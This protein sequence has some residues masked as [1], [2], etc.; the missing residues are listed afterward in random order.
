[1]V[2]GD[3]SEIRQPEIPG[4]PGITDT[5]PSSDKGAAD[6]KARRRQ[7]QLAAAATGRGDTI[8]TSPLGVVNDVGGGPQ[9]GKQLL[10]L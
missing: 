6:E 2:G 9:A 1:L 8:L 5:T 7:R 10:G 3:G 4:M